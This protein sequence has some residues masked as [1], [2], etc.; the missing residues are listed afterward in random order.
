ME[1]VLRA[2]EH[3]LDPVEIIARREI[4]IG[5]ERGTFDH[6]ANADMAGQL[7]RH[8]PASVSVPWPATM[9]PASAEATQSAMLASAGL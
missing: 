7:D 5:D 2:R 9:M 6:R 8:Q 3:A 4:V 1:L